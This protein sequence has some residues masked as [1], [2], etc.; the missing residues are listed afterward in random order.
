MPELSVLATYALAVLVVELTPGPNMAWLAV[1]SATDGRRAGLAAVAGVGLGLLAIGGA[2]ALG[3]AALINGSPLLYEAL[4]WAGSLFLLYLAFEGWRDAGESSTAVMQSG[5]LRQFGRG[6]VI[7]ALN[8]KAGLFYI[9]VLPEFIDPAHPV[10]LQ[11]GLLTLISVGIATA[12][13]LAIVALAGNAHDFLRDADRN[14][15]VRRV[16]AVLL[17]GIAIWLF[18]S[19]AR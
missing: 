19:T 10:A 4:R 7:N 11:A 6:F 5:S 2:A 12:V 3:L 1:L 16:L 13:H 15:L 9:A 14:R 17:A 8:P 18:L